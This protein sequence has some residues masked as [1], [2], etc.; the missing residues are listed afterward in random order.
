MLQ[1]KADA[2]GD[3]SATQ[4]L[5]P[6]QGLRVWQRFHIRLIGLYGG[7][8]LLSLLLIAALFYNY[9]INSEISHL[10]QRLLSMVTSLAA[11]A[12]AERLAEVPF[13]VEGKSPYHDALYTR[14]AE[15]AATDS[16]V[17][18]IYLLRPTAQ[19]GKLR[20]FVDYVKSGSVAT[21]GKEYDANDLPV[22]L[23]GLQ[24]PAV[25]NQPYRDEFGLTL[26]GYAPVRDTQGH[27]VA[28]VGVDVQA[29]HI[30]MI[31]QAVLWTTLMVF[32]VSILLIGVVSVAVAHSVRV[33]LSLIID[34][35]AAIAGG[36]LHTRLKFARRDEFG[37]MS[38]HVD[39]MAEELEE[40]EFIRTTFGRYVSEE[41]ARQLLQN[42]N[43][44]ALKG[45]ERIVTVLFSDL[46]SYSTICEH[47]APV[48]L[49]E[50]LN[51][52][53]GEMNLLIDAHHGCVIEFLGDAVLAVFG[54]PNQQEAH[55]RHA[56]DCALAMH[57]RLIQ[58]NEEW[59]RSGLARCWNDR[60]IPEL[61]ARIGVHTGRVVAGSQ[62]GATRMKYAI[63]GDA[64]NVAA[65]LE[66][67][68]KELDTRLLI[69]VEAYAQLPDELAQR[70]RSCGMHHVKGREQQV[71]VYTPDG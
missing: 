7:T 66:S 50:M 44:L 68:N 53:L 38:R 21:P 39:R 49:M 22:M 19:R 52:Y 18:S 51:Q 34:A 69:S 65:R 35:L 45:E 16:D 15:A 48:Q 37:L 27:A 10:Q 9:T 25:E 8:V 17:Q 23:R 2:D 40:R 29:Q 32:G 12:D 28:L 61:V 47:L 71:Q 43:H 67:L 54:A 26:S 13:G 5:D 20:F 6:L 4:A 70:F 3:V 46:A 60:G 64:V 14:F 58:L 57:E 41:V 36:A 30:D 56:V 63:I 33:P 31:K 11:S 59:C 62:G 24:A 1:S 55:A 42:R